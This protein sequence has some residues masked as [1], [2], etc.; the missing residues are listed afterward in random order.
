[1]HRD[2]QR[3]HWHWHRPRWIRVRQA[4]R[5]IIFRCAWCGRK[6]LRADYADC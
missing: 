1:M 6:K 4:G 3:W 5:V 2:G